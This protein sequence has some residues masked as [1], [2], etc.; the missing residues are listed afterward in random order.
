MIG[1]QA[2]YEFL[3]GNI[4]DNTLNGT[5]YMSIDYES[6]NKQWRKS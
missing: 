4:A 1:A 3:A 6:E 5:A 2:Y